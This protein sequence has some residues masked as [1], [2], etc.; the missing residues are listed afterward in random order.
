[1]KCRDG[2]RAVVVDDDKL[3]SHG[4]GAGGRLENRPSKALASRLRRG[5]LSWS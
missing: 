3:V 2:F 1:M 4:H 5:T